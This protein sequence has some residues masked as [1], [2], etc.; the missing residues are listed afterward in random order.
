M[1]TATATT[2]TL[3]TGGTRGLG[4]ETAR[5]L[6]ESG[7]DVLLG[8]RAPDRARAAAEKVGARPLLVDVTDD[9]S[10][11]A[12]AEQVARETGRLD[13]LIN[14]AGIIGPRLGAADITAAD[15]QA[16]YDTNVFG[17]VR[18]IH[19]FAPLLDNSAAPVVVNV[20]SGLGSIALATDPELRAARVP[21]WIPAPAYG[22]SKAALNMATVQYAHAYP[23]MRINAVDPGHTAT[24]FN[25]HTGPQPVEE[26]AEIIVRMAVAGTGG[27]TGGFFAADGPMPW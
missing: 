6:A 23:R 27:P 21:T 17:A 8:G 15:M 22:S 19:A 10:V 4:L 3:I 25:Q 12:A 1:D 20:S 18:M 2:T 24:D 7:H 9:T 26:G 11:R 13:V 16:T 14:N 5:R